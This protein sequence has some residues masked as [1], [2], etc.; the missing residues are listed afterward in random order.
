MKKTSKTILLT[1]SV[2]TSFAFAK[3]PEGFKWEAIAEV[4]DEFNNGTEFDRSKWLNYHPYWG[5]RNSRYQKHNV[6]VADGTLQLKS[7]LREGAE[8]VSGRTVTAAC[9]T[10]N[11][12]VCGFGYDEA[13]IKASDISM[14]SGFWFQG[15]PIEIDVIENVGD[16]SKNSEKY[17]NRMMMNTHYFYREGRTRKDA[18]TPK[19]HVMSANCSSQYFVYGVWWKDKRNVWFYLDDVKVAEVALEHDFDVLQYMFFD[20]EVFEWAGWPTRESLLDPKKN[21]MYVDW[22]RGWTLV[23]EKSK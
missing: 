15:R 14:T 4:S 11:K 18:S 21:T 6:S 16:S 23:L 19:E 9:V 10:S 8:K 3:P 22:V 1:I 13:G 12:R 5:G 17:K 20:T 7:T 2:L